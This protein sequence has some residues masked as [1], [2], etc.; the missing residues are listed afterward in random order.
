MRNPKR[1]WERPLRPCARRLH[2][3]LLRRLRVQPEKDGV[4]WWVFG[5]GNTQFC[6][7]FIWTFETKAQTGLTSDREKRARKILRCALKSAADKSVHWIWFLF[8]IPRTLTF[9]GARSDHF[10]WRNS[11]NLKMS[12]SSEL[13]NCA[14]RLDLCASVVNSLD[15]QEWEACESSPRRITSDKE[16][17]LCVG[18]LLLLSSK[19]VIP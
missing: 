13:T 12:W 9:C 17:L 4:C 1:V 16:F 6:R 2:L 11:V 7:G 18:F 8:W 10:Q 5:F 19:V 15:C 3:R 14:L